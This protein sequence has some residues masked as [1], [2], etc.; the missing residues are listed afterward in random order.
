MD[1]RPPWEDRSYGHFMNCDRK[2]N[3]KFS[4]K[5]T[6]P[7]YRHSYFCQLLLPA[8]VGSPSC[9]GN[10]PDTLTR[11]LKITF[12]LLLFESLK[13]EI[14]T[15]RTTRTTRTRN[16]Y[17]LKKAPLRS[18]LKL[19]FPQIVFYISDKKEGVSAF[20]ER[21]LVEKSSWHCYPK[22]KR[23]HV[24]IDLLVGTE[25]FWLLWLPGSGTRIGS[26]E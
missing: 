5:Y 8:K 25:L 19:N 12:W 10:E 3:N 6:N 13:S 16:L 4:K 20:L 2:K 14:F 17:K 11:S 26:R 24:Y 21:F 22:L 18:G 7:A 9:M 23:F 1:E 15:T